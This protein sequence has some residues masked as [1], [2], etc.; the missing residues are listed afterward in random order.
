MPRERIYYETYTIVPVQY[1][2]TRPGYPPY[3]YKS[4]FSAGSQRQDV[5]KSLSTWRNGRAY[6]QQTDWNA[7]GCFV[8]A[9]MVS[10]KVQPAGLSWTTE[11][12]YASC[13]PNV[14]VGM[15]PYV[16][17]TDFEPLVAQATTKA[18]LRLKNQKVNLGV[19][20]AEARD[21]ARLLGDTGYRLGRLA[22]EASRRK[23]KDWFSGIRRAGT[24]DWKNVPG[25]YLEQVYGW[26]PLLSDVDGAM[27]QL[28]ETL[29][30]GNSP[31][32]SAKG[33]A[34]DSEDELL[35]ITS[36][37]QFGQLLGAGTR[38]KRAEV[39]LFAEAPSWVLQD[40]SS[41]GITNPF[42]IAWERVP[43]SHVLDWILPIGNWINTWDVGNYLTLK[44]GYTT[45]FST[46]QGTAYYVGNPASAQ[47]AVKTDVPGRYRRYSMDRRVLSRFPVA[48][49]PSLRNPLSLDHMAQGLAMF[50]QVVKKQSRRAFGIDVSKD[51]D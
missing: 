5:P 37:L 20:L 19:A 29:N 43:Y 45:R 18:L 2:E 15:L 34:S 10:G 24:K 6:T 38:T 12:D 1:R 41:L 48:S 35:Q 49:F 42:S 44:T 32:V 14:G 28:A 25:F 23:P 33:R 30:R 50:S 16:P 8:T 9:P 4:N 40:Y 31:L 7:R 47:W 51:T 46:S 22:Q 3:N 21:A 13:L 17:F 36:M 26:A 27:Q 11:F 39:G